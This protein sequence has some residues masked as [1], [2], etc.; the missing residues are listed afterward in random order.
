[1][2]FLPAAVLVIALFWMLTAQVNRQIAQ[3][4]A[5]ISHAMVIGQTHAQ[6][7]CERN[8]ASLHAVSLDLDQDVESFGGL[9]FHV[10]CTH[11]NG[12]T[13]SRSLVVLRLIH[14]IFHE[15]ELWYCP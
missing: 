6:R 5:E 10:T 14:L 2:R 8:G 7:L 1:M 15:R 13:F 4:H 9:P 11:R 3:I 12:T